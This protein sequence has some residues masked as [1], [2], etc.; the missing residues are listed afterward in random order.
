VILKRD[1]LEEIRRDP[2]LLVSILLSFTQCPSTEPKEN[3][4]I[5]TTAHIVAT[6]ESP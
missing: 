6:P 1:G 2:G 4:T 3:G 5:G